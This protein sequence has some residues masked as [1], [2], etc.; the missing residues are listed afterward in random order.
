MGES[1]YIRR[2]LFAP[3]IQHS[4]PRSE[5]ASSNFL[6]AMA[7]LS[8]H[9]LLRATKLFLRPLSLRSLSSRRLLKMLLYFASRHCYGRCLS[10]GGTRAGCVFL[11]ANALTVSSSVSLPSPTLCLNL[12][13][14]IRGAA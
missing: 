3:V 14:A 10:R 11:S 5:K 13:H 2:I 1:R 7:A 4:G 9:I 6:L 12:Y 8:C